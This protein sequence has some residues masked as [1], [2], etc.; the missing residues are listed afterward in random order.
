MPDL[1]QLKERNLEDYQYMIVTSTANKTNANKLLPDRL[2]SEGSILNV[3]VSTEQFA[4]KV[5]T[6][7]DGIIPHIFVDVER[8]QLVSIWDTATKICQKS[9]IHP[10]K[11]N[12]ITVDAAVSTVI[13]ELKKTFEKSSVLIYG[14]GN[15]ATKTALKLAELGMRVTLAGR[16]SKKV[17][18]I[19]GVLN[20]ILPS[21]T[22]WQIESYQSS[23]DMRADVFISAISAQKVVDESWLK[24]LNPSGFVLDMGLNNFTEIF[25]A[26]TLESKR[27][28]YRVDIQAKIGTAILDLKTKDYFFHQIR[29]RM[30][31]FGKM[32]VAGGII[33]NENDIVLD[34]ITPPH[35]IIGTSNGTG[36]LK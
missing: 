3:Q 24:H 28:L 14:T 30:E 16:D 23:E 20:T 25:I 22:P 29:G 33:G 4:S 11:A 15:L 35:A 21:Y 34:K 2:S 31:W 26:S 18:R 27:T 19:V 32:A 7:V 13:E 10:L 9:I 12:D 6:L 17:D 1:A 36:G 8:K 5:L